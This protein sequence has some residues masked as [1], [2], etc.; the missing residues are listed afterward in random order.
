M[1]LKELLRG[2]EIEEIRGSDEI[3]IETTAY[4]SREIANNGLFIC[5][6]GFKTDG[7][8]YI[9]DAIGKGAVAAIVQKDINIEGITIIK[10]KDTRKAMAIISNGF[11]QYPSNTLSL[12]GVT[13]TNGKT[14]TTY[15]IKK[16]FEASG[17]KSGL[18]GT[19]S[20]WIG[21]QK[22]DADRTTPEALDLQR[23]FRQMIDNNMETCVME[24]SSH[25]LELKRVEECKFQVGVFTNLTP[26][27]L[28]FHPT[29][30]DY[31]NA[32]KKLF[33]KT[34]LCNAINIDDE[35][36]KILM[37]EI[38]G[39]Q[40]PILTYAI[41]EKADINAEN[42][43]TTVKTVAFDV[44]T[45]KYK[46]RIELSIPGLFTVYNA[47]AAITVAY[48]MGIEFK[49]IKE[50]LESMK[51]VPGRLEAVEEFIDF[52]LIVDYAHTP[53]ALENVL[54]SVKGFVENKLITIFG[55]G[56]DRDRRK[57]PVM[58][59]ISGRYS[60]LTIITSDNPRSEDPI[61]ILEMI[62][63][64]IRKTDGQYYV[65]KDRKEA[66]RFA[67][68]SAHKGDVILIAGKGH[69][70]YQIIND[71]VLEFDDKKVA[72]EVAREEGLI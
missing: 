65:I 15:M 24:V 10:V 23:L 35:H 36:G 32:K 30:E 19:I 43:V 59:E 18:I 46:E 21:D 41:N 39:L 17:K 54:K 26:D 68:R 9:E 50:G 29:I 3:T 60:D 45:P 20:N 25:S 64:G 33:Y 27:H 31:R 22:I 52:A 63:E 67:L 7:H 62:E 48:A 61:Q 56:G 47:L 53:D 28:D 72:L 16:I 55:C 40:T 38:N 1:L 66:I 14:S 58:G 4:D 5:I 12:I 34:I 6:E 37:K 44:I 57:R 42:I 51:G 69:E 11:Y 8:L 70:T 13:G 2:L 71:E 49:Y